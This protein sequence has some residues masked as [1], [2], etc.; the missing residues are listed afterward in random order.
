MTQHALPITIDPRIHHGVPV[1]TGTRVPVRIVVG[2]LAGGMTFAQ[3]QDEYSV[4]AEQI[5]AALKFA[6]EQLEL[7]RYYP[8]SA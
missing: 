6:A 5:R 7:S 1:I 3:V 4:T 8:L 2:S